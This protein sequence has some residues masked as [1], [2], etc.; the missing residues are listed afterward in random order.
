MR[1]EWRVWIRP[2]SV[3]ATAAYQFDPIGANELGAQFGA[4]EQ[5]YLGMLAIDP[6]ERRKY[7]GRALDDDAYKVSNSI[8]ATRYGVKQGVRTVLRLARAKKP[9]R[10]LRAIVSVMSRTR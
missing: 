4:T 6:L 7:S 5:Y 10:T 9:P 3:K 8:V 2:T 1:T